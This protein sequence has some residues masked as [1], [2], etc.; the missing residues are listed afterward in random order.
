MN[1][2]DGYEEYTGT[3]YKCGGSAFDYRQS[4]PHMS[5][6]CM[7]CGSFIQHVGKIDPK[8]KLAEWKKQIKERDGYT[9]QRCGA[10]VNTTQC[11]AHHKMPV[12]FMPELQ[13][14]PDNGITLCKKCHHALH[15][16]GGTIKEKEN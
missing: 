5:V 2:P 4:G 10:F 11:D 7:W 14:D 13:F 12:W 16:A 6:Y 9:C 1:C 15:G 3:C 8:K